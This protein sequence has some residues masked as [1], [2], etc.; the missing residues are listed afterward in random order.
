MA[1]ELREIVPKAIAIQIDSLRAGEKWYY[2]R[3]KD[4]AFFLGASMVYTQS[5]FKLFKIIAKLSIE[6]LWRASKNKY[7][8]I[9]KKSLKEQLKS[10]NENNKYLRKVINRGFING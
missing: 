5:N 6:V 3:D 7:D 2:V 10:Q 4:D 8:D 9:E 1:K